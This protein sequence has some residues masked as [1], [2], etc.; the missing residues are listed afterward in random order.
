[1]F[2]QRFAVG[3]IYGQCKANKEDI[4]LSKKTYNL[5]KVWNLVELWG[6]DKKG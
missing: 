6:P 3:M 1:M 5:A 2:E 4:Y